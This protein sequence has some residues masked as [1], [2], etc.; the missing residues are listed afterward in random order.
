MEFDCY[1]AKE[2][3]YFRYRTGAIILRG[4]KMLFVKN[5]LEGYYYMIGGA[6][7]LGETSRDCIEREVFE[8]TGVKCKAIR[9]GIICEN[10]FSGDRL[11][12]RI[13]DKFCHILEFYYLMEAPEGSAFQ[14]E[15]DTNEELVWIDLDEIDNY[16]VRPVMLKTKLK[17]A[18]DGGH[19]LHVINDDFHHI[20]L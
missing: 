16:D 8:E 14:E 4:K 17:E 18:I 7:H 1:L 13:K 12:E 11:D 5:F 10:F 6:V 20:I 15:T 9:P 3:Y 19:V 2:N